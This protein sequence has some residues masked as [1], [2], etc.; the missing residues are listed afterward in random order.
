MM[1]TF[2]PDVDRPAV[3]SSG[4][5]GGFLQHSRAIAGGVGRRLAGA[6]TG[7]PPVGL[8]HRARDPRQRPAPLAHQPAIWWGLQIT[9]T[10]GPDA[11]DVTGTILASPA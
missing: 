10:R 5:A 1:S 7:R 9:V 11:L 2:R 3:G 8:R 4:R 6:T